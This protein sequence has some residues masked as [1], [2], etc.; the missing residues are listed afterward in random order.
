MA[1]LPFK[2][3]NPGCPCCGPAENPPG[4][5]NCPCACYAFEDN[6]E[7]SSISNLHLTSTSMSYGAGKLDKAAA[8]DGT[9]SATHS[10]DSCYRAGSGINVWFWIKRDVYNPFKSSG[11]SQHG[12]GIIAADGAFP[13]P[14]G[15]LYVDLSIPGYGENYTGFTGSWAIYLDRD[16]HISSNSTLNFVVYATTGIGQLFGTM[17]SQLNPSVDGDYTAPWI[18]CY[19]WWDR[20]NNKEYL[21]RWGSNLSDSG[22]LKEETV[23]VATR[24][25]ATAM[26]EDFHCTD[27][28]GKGFNGYNTGTVYLD[29][30]GICKDIGTKAEMEE[31][32]ENL[33]N[34]GDG[35]E[36]NHAGFEGGGCCG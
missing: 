26:T 18:F 10:F 27:G 29:N 4:G 8:C 15:P 19:W 36:C 11:L 20:A 23:S 32:A 24:A 25:Q 7:D 14:D 30:L 6:A 33:W 17:M 22:V 3:N 2:K 35:R 1:V 9:Q 13:Q 12:A 5:P 21:I 34:D 31:R 28:L 16:S